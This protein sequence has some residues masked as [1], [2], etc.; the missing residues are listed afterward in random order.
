M[1]TE[2]ISVMLTPAVLA[3]LDAYAAEHRWS[4]SAA[5]GVLIE[6]RLAEGTVSAGEERGS[7]N[8]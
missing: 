2:K 7:G 4:R 6:Q 5:A 1:R 3:A 8:P